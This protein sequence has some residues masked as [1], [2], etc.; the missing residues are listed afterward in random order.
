MTTK[1]DN[2]VFVVQQAIK[3]LKCR[4]SSESV[5]DFLLGHPHY[6][7]LKAVCDL[8]KKWGIEYYALKLTAEEIF[9]LDIPFIAHLNQAGGQLAFVER[10]RNNTVIWQQHKGRKHTTNIEEFAKQISGAV[11]L[12]EPRQEAGEPGFRQKRQDKWIK[13]GLLPA[14]ILTIVLYALYNFISN[15]GIHLNS[16][17]LFLTLTKLLGITASTFLILHELKIHTSIGDK[18]CGF[19]SKTDCGAVLTSNASLLFGNI[20]WADT[21]II[22]FTGTILYFMATNSI[23]GLGILALLSVIL[24]PY[25]IFSIYYQSVKLKKWCPF[26]LIVQLVL[27]TEFFI[28]HPALKNVSLQLTELCRLAFAFMLPATAWII[29]KMY[30]EKSYK[31]DQEHYSFL[32]LKRDPEL[33]RFLLKKDGYTEFTETPDSLMLGNP[34]APVTLTAFLSLYCN[35]CAQAFKKLKVLLENCPDI[36]LNAVFS[37]YNDDETQQIINTLYYFKSTIGSNATLELIDSWY[38]LSKSS[39][40]SLLDKEVISE[41]SKLSEQVGITNRQLFAKY[42]IAGTPTIYVNGYRFPVQYE[43]GDLE[44]YIDDIKHLNLEGK[45]KEACT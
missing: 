19:S 33:F 26:C 17:F 5:K 32:K 22:Y 2:T 11:I 27:I 8:L 29:F 40:K 34:N 15:P 10:I 45:R 12:I 16:A 18:L 23:D 7:S 21:G 3:K 14:A 41:Q 24:L 36:K 39:K 31:F 4:I 42:Q 37:V 35:P 25:P 44:Y 6:P 20:N 1:E 13:I 30:L 28:L 43:Y 38:S 9:A